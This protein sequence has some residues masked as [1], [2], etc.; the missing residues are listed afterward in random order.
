MGLEFDR[1]GGSERPTRVAY[2]APRTNRAAI[3][4]RALD[5]LPPRVLERAGLLLEVVH[6]LGER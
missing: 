3:S 6:G 2:G 1:K 4:S 5:R